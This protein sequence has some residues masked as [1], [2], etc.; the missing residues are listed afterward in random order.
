MADD[1]WQQKHALSAAPAA[2]ARGGGED[3]RPNQPLHLPTEG[4]VEADA[5]QVKP[6]VLHSLQRVQDVEAPV[7]R[8]AALSQ[9]VVG[10]TDGG[11]HDHRLPL[12][13]HKHL[14]GTQRPCPHQRGGA[15]SK[16]CHPPT[17]SQLRAEKRKG[18]H[19]Q[20]VIR[21]Q[22]SLPVADK[23]RGLWKC[24]FPHPPWCPQHI[25]TLL[26]LPKRN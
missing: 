26:P 20:Q 16:G 5:L 24:R 23:R 7:E 3:R 14:R 22:C 18:F 15:T 4:G 17:P 6:E 25:P 10:L 12:Q 1:P 11:V 9:V 21:Q 2:L 13:V 8:A 19:S